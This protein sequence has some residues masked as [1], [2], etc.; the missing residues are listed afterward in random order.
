MAKIS[1]SPIVD[2]IRGALGNSVIQQGKANSIVRKRAIPSNPRSGAQ[3]SVRNLVSVR[4]KAWASLTE[5]QR[6][7]WDSAASSATWRQTDSMG[8]QFQLSGEQL[9][10]KLNLQ[11]AAIDETAITSPPVKEAFASLSVGTITATA[12]T[13]SLSVAYGG[14]LG[15]NETLLL[16]MS[17]KASAG[18]MSAKSVSFVDIQYTAAASPINALTAYVARFGALVAGQKLWVELVQVN[19][20]TGEANVVGRASKIVAA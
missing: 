13:P 15:A 5:A 14:T 16:R 1:F 19:A 20:V 4:S 10:M 2:D 8:R 11:L 7:A 17:N 6:T 9:Y 3:I 18:I 12:G